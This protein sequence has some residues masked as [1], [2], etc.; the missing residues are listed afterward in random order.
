MYYCMY[1]YIQRQHTASSATDESWEWNGMLRSF[2]LFH[3]YSQKN[4]TERKSQH[5]TMFDASV[6]ISGGRKRRHQ[7]L[8][9]TSWYDLSVC[10][11]FFHCAEIFRKFLF[12]SSYD[13]ESLRNETV[14]FWWRKRWLTGPKKSSFFCVKFRE[15]SIMILQIISLWTNTASTWFPH[16]PVSFFFKLKYSTVLIYTF[17]HS[18]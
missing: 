4:N 1:I 12:F 14:R 11:V 2:L 15:I 17:A 7:C 9:S 13:F 18:R 3:Y 5:P 8:R 16:T 10:W 6:A